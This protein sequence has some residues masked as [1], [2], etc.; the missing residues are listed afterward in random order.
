MQLLINR[1]FSDNSIRWSTGPAGL[2]LC[3]GKY[4]IF[5]VEEGPLC[6]LQSGR[7]L[8]GVSPISDDQYKAAFATTL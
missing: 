3:T 4:N 5:L 7:K 8:L 6:L 1:I 2:R